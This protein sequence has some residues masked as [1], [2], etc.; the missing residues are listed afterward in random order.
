[1]VVRSAESARSRQLQATILDKL[2]QS[3]SLKRL[4]G[5]VDVQV[6]ERGLRIELVETGAATSLPDRLSA[7]EAGHDARAAAHRRPSSRSCKHPVVLEG[8]TDAAPFGADGGY[9]NWEL[10]ADRANAARRVLETVGRAGGRIVEVRGYADT[11]PTRPRRSARRRQS[12]HLDPAALYQSTAGEPTAEAM[13]AGK[14]DSIIA[15][16]GNPMGKAPAPGSAP[17]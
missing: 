16:I 8:H 17:R 1:M 5:L 2:A 13:A 3:D 9:G 11:K 12:P 10:S 14:R 15:G 6:T 4:N 7:D